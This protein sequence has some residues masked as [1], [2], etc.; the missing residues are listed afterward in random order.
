MKMSIET[1]K[2]EDLR[3]HRLKP[4]IEFRCSYEI[5]NDNWETIDS[6]ELRVHDWDFENAEAHFHDLMTD[7]MSSVEN[8]DDYFLTEMKVGSTVKIG[9]TYLSLEPF[10]KEIA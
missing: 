9:K 1:T 10:E 8:A 5:T 7:K 3:Y 6:G 4:R 2:N